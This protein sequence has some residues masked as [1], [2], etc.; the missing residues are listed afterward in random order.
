M[1]N[2]MHKKIHEEFKFGTNKIEP[3]KLSDTAN[4]ETLS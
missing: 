2:K 1:V 4:L 3:K